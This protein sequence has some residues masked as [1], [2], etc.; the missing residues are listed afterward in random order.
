MDAAE[1]DFFQAFLSRPVHAEGHVIIFL[2]KT[3]AKRKKTSEMLVG[4][5]KLQLHL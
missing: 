2:V 3:F 1:Q 5:E 4:Y